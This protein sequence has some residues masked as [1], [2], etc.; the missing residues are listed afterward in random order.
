[1]NLALRAS[2][3]IEEFL[4]WEERQDLRYEFDGMQAV[5]MTGGTGAHSMIQRNLAMALGN[6]L[7]GKP[8]QYIG[9]DLKIEA[10]G[11][12]RYPDGYVVCSPVGLR[13]T[14][15]RDPVV[16]FEVLSDSTARID[17]VVKNIEY[18]AIPSVKR[19]IVLSQDEIAGLMYERI[20]ADWVG[21]LLTADAL[22]SMP[23]IGIEVALSEFYQGVPFPS[24]DDVTSAP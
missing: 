6:R 9:N 24:C 5:A 12:I 13:T 21:H 23:E 19:Y 15:V 3:T 20:D 8:C 11:R 10:A 4:A 18:S 1:M 14:V 2:T 17:L 22:I 7:V 16:I